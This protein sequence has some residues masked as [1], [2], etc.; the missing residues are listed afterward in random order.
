ME[1]PIA[2]IFQGEKGGPVKDKLNKVI[3]VINSLGDDVSINTGLL[4]SYVFFRNNEANPNT[5][6]IDI[7]LYAYYGWLRWKVA[8]DVYQVN[9]GNTGYN[10][11]LDEFDGEE[12][13]SRIDTIYAITP[14]TLAQPET[15]I[16]VRKGTNAE[17]P[18]APG[19]NTATEVLLGYAYVNIGGF[20]EGTGTGA[21]DAVVVG[22]GKDGV[23]G[24]QAVTGKKYFNNRILFKQGIDIA[25]ANNIILPAGRFFRLSDATNELQTINN[26]GWTGGT[27]ILLEI[28]TGTFVKHAAPDYGLGNYNGI[29]L[30]CQNDFTASQD[31]ILHLVWDSSSR[32]WKEVGGTTIAAIVERPWYTA[33]RVQAYCEDVDTDT[34][35]T[36]PYSYTGYTIVNNGTAT[37]EIVDNRIEFTSAGTAYNIEFWDGATLI[38]TLPLCE[39]PRLVSDASFIEEMRNRWSSEG[40]RMSIMNSAGYTTHDNSQEMYAH[41]YGFCRVETADYIID[42]PNLIGGTVQSF[43]FLTL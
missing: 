9:L 41:F 31:L 15:G 18:I 16:K 22:T 33:L 23:N 10:I 20:S 28:K 1:L 32:K 2:H 26:N 38:D 25:S 8:G 27:D 11:T 12:G 5:P 42:V 24:Y 29:L 21:D 6:D 3:D 39:A 14:P 43:L 37:C 4:S 19:I 13:E 36:I 40:E 30:A 7:L 17:N 35:I 34:Y